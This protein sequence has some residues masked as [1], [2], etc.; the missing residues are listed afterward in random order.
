MISPCVVTIPEGKNFIPYTIFVPSGTRY[1]VEYKTNSEEY[2]QTGYYGGD[3]GTVKE[4]DAAVLLDVNEGGQQNIDIEL[5]KNKKITGDFRL[6]KGV[7]PAG[8]F[9]AYLAAPAPAGGISV[10]LTVANKT[11]KDSVDVLIPEGFT[12]AP[13]ELYIP[14]GEN[15]VLQY[16]TSNVGFVSSGYYSESGT[17]E[18]SSEA[19]LLNILSDTEGLDIA[20]ITKRTIRGMI[21]LPEGYA[22]AAGVNVKL[23][24][25]SAKDN[26]SANFTVKEGENSIPYTLY[27]SSDQEYIVRYETADEKYVSL[28][29]YSM[30]GTT[31]ELSEADRL[32]TTEADQ[33][34][35]NIKLISNRYIAGSISVPSGIAPFGGIKVL[36]RAS[37]GKDS[38][39]IEVV[40]PEVSSSTTY[41]LYVP[42]GKDY[43]LSYRILNPDGKY[44]SS[45][46][47]NAG[48]ATRER[49]ECVLIDLS[50]QSKE[51]INMTL[52][53]N[54]L[55]TGNIL[56]PSGVAPLGGL[57]ITVIAQ[58]NRDLVS[59]QV[60]MPQGSSSIVYRMYLPEG[61]D[62]TI[63]YSISHEDYLS[64]YYN[65]NDTVLNKMDATTFNI[66]KNDIAGIN[67][68][69]IPKRTIKG[70]ISLPDGKT[71]PAGGIDVTVTAGSYSTKVTI[72]QN[73]STALYTLK[74]SPNAVGSGYAVKYTIS[75]SFGFVPT[76]Y[77][78]EEKTVA[79]IQTAS[80]VDVSLGNKTGIDLTILDKPIIQG[81]FEL[82]SGVAPAGGID[83]TITAEGRS[84]ERRAVS[85]QETINIPFGQN[86]SN[87]ELKVDPSYFD[88]G[89]TLKYTM[90]AVYGY[91]ETGYYN[92][93]GTVQNQ[94]D[95]TLINVYE[96]DQGNK[97]FAAIAKNHISGIVSLPEGAVAPKG[98]IKLSIIAENGKGNGSVD[99]TIPEGGIFAGYQLIVPPGTG[100]KL[101]YS[102]TPNN[103]YVSNG[104]YSAEGTV[105][106]PKKA[107]L[108]EMND[109]IEDKNIV[110]I[111]KRKISEEVLL[112]AGEFAPAGGLRVE[113]FANNGASSDSVTV[114]IPENGSSQSFELY[115]PPENGYRLYYTLSSSMEY[116]NKGYYAGTATV[117]E[118]RE[119]SV[120]DLRNEDLIDVNIRFIKN[121]VLKGNVILP[122]GQALEEGIEV[123]ITADNGKYSHSTNVLIPEGNSSTVY[124]LAVPPAAGYTV[125]YQVSTGLD[126]KPKGYY[127]YEGTVT[128]INEVS[129]LDLSSR[130]EKDVD[131]T[132]IHYNSISGTISLPEGVAPGE[133]VT[134]TLFANNSRNKRELTVTIP[135]EKSSTDY[136]IYVPD[137]NGYKVYYVM[138]PNEEYVDKGYYASNR[139]AVNEKDCLTVDV[140]G[141]SVF[142]TNVTI[143]AKRT[144]SGTISLENSETAPQQGISVRISALEGDEQTVVIPYGKS[145]ASYSLKVVPNGPGEGY[146]VKFETL[147][148]YGYIRYG[149]Y[150]EDGSIRNE[151]KAQR[152]DVSSCDRE[153]IDFEIV[154]PRT[155]EGSLRLPEDVEANKDMTVSVIASNNLDSAEVS[156]FIPKGTREVLEYNYS[157]QDK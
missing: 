88:L 110:L 124:S 16:T 23:T 122:T 9:K 147:K 79:G 149:Y 25:Q 156:V 77:H 123:R 54:R 95:A 30:S 120:I 90:D 98:G 136:N 68:T 93:S 31:R 35:V 67:I 62:Y 42:E 29:Y 12:S 134:V 129:K 14:T 5:I 57:K 65:V 55:V 115:M 109:N 99:V 36:L 104:Y 144:I 103:S 101:Y 119:A 26:I 105:I 48:T 116:V 106:D 41:R 45:G 50:E 131:L 75:T 89:Y 20:L 70:V 6:S 10:K 86:Q 3:E 112:P 91:A 152:V 97:N 52:I 148:N 108:F 143:I 72:P 17:K 128:S 58:N 135:A 64:G 141:D 19:L 60:I 140:I 59:T 111:A 21:M 38:R 51:G 61:E 32:D 155:I 15:Y 13:Y 96:E 73:K 78:G 56:L 146:K 80:L 125:S 150:S 53:P 63:G 7:A 107:E 24:A 145:T 132:L 127:S 151:A 1:L 34:G 154:R 121:S 47:Y 138:T 126:Y 4:K 18:K 94:K 71:A 142:D 100:Y 153:D 113:V 76:G 28:G 40:I 27:V 74:V 82:G 44:L 46:Y 8:G 87:F 11:S 37:N 84:A 85:Y 157:W 83:V 69:V 139:T 133:G 118:E 81:V 130:G 2:C 92:D 43:E 137:G 39:E 49:Q 102:M 66:R 33:V 114:F 117:L 22:P